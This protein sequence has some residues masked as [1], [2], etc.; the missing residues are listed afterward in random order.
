MCQYRSLRSHYYAISS[1]CS[2]MLAFFIIL[3]YYAILHLIASSP[4][5]DVGPAVH[6]KAAK[7]C[8]RSNVIRVGVCIATH[9]GVFT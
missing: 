7:T 1:L 5:S 6:S 4:A 3:L 2:I 9:L 8:K